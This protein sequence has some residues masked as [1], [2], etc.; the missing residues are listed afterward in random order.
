MPKLSQELHSLGNIPIVV[1]GDS[2][3][4]PLI[5][6]GEHH[7][8]DATHT[9]FHLIDQPIY[10]RVLNVVMWSG[11]DNMY[12]R[13]GSGY[14]AYRREGDLLG[15]YFIEAVT[16]DREE[17]FRACEPESLYRATIT[18]RRAG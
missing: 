1:I 17:D 8:L 18:M 7:V 6:L 13:A 5:D 15:V 9:V 10:K 4:E 14:Y 11:Y 12:S 3:D 2:Y 16:G